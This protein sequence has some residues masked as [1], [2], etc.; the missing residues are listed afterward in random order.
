MRAGRLSFIEGAR[1]ICD[2]RGTSR[3]DVEDP[4]VQAFVVIESETDALPVGALRELWAP[5]AL[6][7]IQPRLAASEAWAKT[8][9]EA[10]CE[11]FIRRFGRRGYPQLE[12]DASGNRIPQS[13]S[14]EERNA[15]VALLEFLGEA[16]KLH[17]R[18]LEGCVVE[19]LRADGSILRFYWA[20]YV[21]PDAPERH[22]LPTLGSIMDEDGEDMSL[23][24]Y[25]DS[26]G[27]LFEMEFIR[28]GPGDV[29]A[30][31]WSTFRVVPLA[32]K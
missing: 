31:D 11:S 25:A 27:R 9:G 16:G 1:L 26:N 10:A 3:L 28:W 21:R 17:L 22:D 12:T 18:D 13:L 19:E 23:V 14:D 6:D 29:V 7:A 20:G 32:K 15:A 24:L 8:I 2:L 30:P 5:E 4:D